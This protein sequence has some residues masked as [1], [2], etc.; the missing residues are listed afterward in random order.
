[1]RNAAR[2]TGGELPPEPREDPRAGAAALRAQYEAVMRALEATR[3]GDLM[4]EVIA[5][6][7]RY[8]AHA[9]A[10]DRLL[11]ARHGEDRAFAAGVALGE[12]RAAVRQAAPG[13]RHAAGR[14]ILSVVR[15]LVPAGAVGLA[16]RMWA[17]HRILAPVALASL[18]TAAGV[19]TLQPARTVPDYGSTA[20]RFSVPGW[21][22][23]AV[24]IPPA[25]PAALAR[26]KAGA[27]R[28]RHPAPASLPPEPSG[29]AS[30]S[31]SPPASPS[32]S[33]PPAV[34]LVS[35]REIDLGVL[36]SSALTLAAPQAAV[37]WT[38]ACSPDVSLSS[39]SGILA[40]GQ[41]GYRLAVR[42]D[43]TDGAS[44]GTCTFLPGGEK[45]TITWAN[46]A[47]PAASPVPAP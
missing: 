28:S 15:V 35:T 27:A 30:P 45:L 10:L 36:M 12:Q 40:S 20:P 2:N 22:T 46:G 17:A 29:P 21:Q 9:A 23:G 4:F 41:Q 32:P 1:M 25:S 24:P 13:P 8:A 43:V 39:S 18:V 11:A 3:N 16:A 31:P 6:G 34:L 5:L 44:A 37:T 19:V 14:V 42:I 47:V 33:G 26:P 38:A 7:R